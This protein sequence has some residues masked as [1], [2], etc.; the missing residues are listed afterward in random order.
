MKKEKKARVVGGPEIL[1][2]VLLILQIGLTV[3]FQMMLRSGTLAAKLFEN[4]R[5]DKAITMIKKY[6]IKNNSSIR[7]QLTS[8]AE[9]I[10]DDY[11]EEKR[12]YDQIY[13]DIHRYDELD[14]YGYS[15]QDEESTIEQI[16]VSR[17]MLSAAN[18]IVSSGESSGTDYANAVNLYSSLSPLDT[19]YYPQIDE[20]K[21]Q[22]AD[23]FENKLL[24]SNIEYGD[25]LNECDDF[26]SLCDDADINSRISKLRTDYVSGH[27]NSITTQL[28]DLEN[29]GEYAE[30]ID[31][32]DSMK[33]SYSSDTEFV[34]TL[35]TRRRSFITLLIT[36]KLDSGSYSDSVR[37]ADKY[38]SEYS[39]TGFASTLEDLKGDCVSEWVQ[40]QVSENAY[41]G[42]NGAIKLVEQYDPLY[43]AKQIKKTVCTGFKNHIN[44]LINNSEFSKAESLLTSTKDFIND[45]SSAVGFKYNDKLA[46]LYASWSSKQSDL[47]Y[48]LES[49]NSDQSALYYAKKANSL[50]SGSVSIDSIYNA[51]ADEIKNGTVAE[52]FT[53]RD[54]YGV[55]RPAYYTSNNNFAERLAQYSKQGINSFDNQ[56]FWEMANSY[57]VSADSGCHHWYTTATSFDDFMEGFSEDDLYK[58]YQDSDYNQVGIG[59]CIDKD[60]ETIYVVLC[61]FY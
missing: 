58:L 16:N 47:G 11:I 53:K 26:T 8:R 39:D 27:K 51:C 54:N 42:T 20:L 14:D 59:T 32:I 40:H 52:I 34:D 56:E 60:A 18:T 49:N 9:A 15:V 57:G 17:G 10:V 19:K 43:P 38:I 13:E 44:S 24:Y 2:I 29:R 55:A 33:G 25:F 61:M 3:A 37:Y 50:K 41:T 12:S 21:T 7:S 36:S 5:T 45:N 28:D 48:Y 1:L 31:L 35:E 4:G 6:N 46:A 30:A 22:A 23:A